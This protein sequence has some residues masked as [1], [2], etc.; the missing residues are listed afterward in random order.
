M[1]VNQIKTII[2]LYNWKERF[3]IVLP[4][5]P[6]EFLTGH[7]SL[8]PPEPETRNFPPGQPRCYHGYLRS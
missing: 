4:L 5:V 7:R 8:N 1:N 2:F 6:S 3:K